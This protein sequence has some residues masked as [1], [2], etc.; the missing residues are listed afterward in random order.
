MAVILMLTVFVF[1]LLGMKLFGG[2]FA[3]P[4]EALPRSN[5]DTFFTAALTVFQVLTGEN[6]GFRLHTEC[7]SCLLCCV[8]YCVVGF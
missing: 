4:A 8:G 2:K 1:S 6:P 7:F 5:F 3:F